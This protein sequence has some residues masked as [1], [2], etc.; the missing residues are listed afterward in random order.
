MTIEF[1]LYEGDDFVEIRGRVIAVNECALYLGAVKSIA[2]PG[3]DPM[4]YF[5][6][7]VRIAHEFINP[8]PS[9]PFIPGQEVSVFVLEGYAKEIGF[10]VEEK[11][12]Q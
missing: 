7:P 5:A 1:P 4:K 9:D 6:Q 12:A 11:K 8:V 2:E 10:R 3:V